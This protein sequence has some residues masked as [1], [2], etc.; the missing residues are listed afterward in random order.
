MDVLNIDLDEINLRG[1]ISHDNVENGKDYSDWNRAIKRSLY[2]DDVL[3]TVSNVVVKANDLVTIDGIG[4]VE[5]EG[6][7]YRTYAV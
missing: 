4:Y 2:M 5:W 6:E 1:R 3:Y 7:D